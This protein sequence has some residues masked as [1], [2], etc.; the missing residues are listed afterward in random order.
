M[1]YIIIGLLAGLYPFLYFLTSVID[2]QIVEA[3]NRTIA[4]ANRDR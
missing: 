2:G 4:A 1:L 3:T